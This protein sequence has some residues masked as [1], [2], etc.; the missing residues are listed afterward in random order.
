MRF[1]TLLFIALFLFFNHQPSIINRVFAQSLDPNTWQQGSA[2]LKTQTQADKRTGGLGF[3]VQ[4][5]GWPSLQL[6][7]GVMSSWN[8][9]VPSLDLYG[10]IDLGL[11]KVPN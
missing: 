9:L 2:G 10:A 8:K 6:H 1:K 5:K 3:R 11:V 7:G 4:D